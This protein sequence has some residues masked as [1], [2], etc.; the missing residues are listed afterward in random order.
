VVAPDLIGQSGDLIH[1]LVA[2]DA[3]DD[4]QART[5]DTEHTDQKDGH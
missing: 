5:D 3:M 1:I 2:D 4:L